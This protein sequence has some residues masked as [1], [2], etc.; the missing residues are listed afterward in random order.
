MLRILAVALV[1]ASLAYSSSALA[2]KPPSDP[3]HQPPVQPANGGI[4]GTV[5]CADTHKP[6]RGALVLLDTVPSANGKG[7]HATG[8]SGFARVAV[9]GTY[10]LEDVEPGEYVV[11]AALPGYLAPF[12]GPVTAPA[13]RPGEKSI[14]K[15]SPGDRRVRLRPGKTETVDLTLERGAAISGRVL[16]PDGSP[17][18]QIAVMAEDIKAAPSDNQSKGLEAFARSMLIHPAPV[19]DDLGRF[20]ISGIAAG[21]Y[22]I[23]V[24]QSST[25]GPMDG[26]DGMMN[27][28]P[29]IITNGKALRIYSGDTLHR[30]A[31]KQ[32]ELRGPDEVTGLEITLPTDTFHS[33]QGLLTAKDG[34]RI[35]HGAVTLTDSTDNTLTFQG[36][37]ERDGTF[38]FS[39]VPEG[40]YTLEAKDAEIGKLPDNLPP[41]APVRYVA[42]ITTNTFADGSTS[43][44]VKDSDVLDLT[45]TLTEIPLPPRERNGLPANSQ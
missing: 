32:Y 13:S 12:D 16:Y 24:V 40:S 26:P 6:A 21:I 33:V 41:T 27:L 14:D 19:T 30:K 31:A 29:G 37:L 7:S 11:S 3:A 8:A 22:R 5:F 4:T 38:R 15:D 9:D 1:S 28:N 25:T 18:I 10:T 2:Q 23:I 44:I 34:R 36:D 17:A 35:N 42:L 43:V 39:G 20:R 45:L